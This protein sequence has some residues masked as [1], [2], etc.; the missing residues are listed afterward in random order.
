[1]SRPVDL[2]LEEVDAIIER[3]GIARIEAFDGTPDEF[4]AMVNEALS[5]PHEAPRP[6]DRGASLFP[7]EVPMID[8]DAVLAADANWRD[9]VHAEQ[10]ARAARRAA[11]IDAR[12]EGATIADIAAALGLTRDAVYKAIRRT[13]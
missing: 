6:F 3:I 10:D 8:L 12:A 11:I 5:P 2:E 1:M 7:K 13:S 9:A 4:W